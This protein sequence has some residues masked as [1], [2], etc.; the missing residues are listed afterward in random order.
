MAA[1]AFVRNSKTATVN[2]NPQTFE[3]FLNE[4]EKK[5]EKEIK[6][7][8]KPQKAT[9]AR[10]HV[11]EKLKKLPKGLLNA[12]LNDPTSPTKTM[13]A[14]FAAYGKWLVDEIL[15]RF[16]EFWQTT[17]EVG[18]ANIIM[19]DIENRPYLIN[20]QENFPT[21]EPESDEEIYANNTDKDAIKKIEMMLLEL[22][23]KLDQSTQ[24][25]LIATKE[26][27]NTRG[28]MDGELDTLRVKHNVEAMPA[29]SDKFYREL[30]QAKDVAQRN[31]IVEKHFENP[32]KDFIESVLTTACPTATLQIYMKKG[33]TKQIKKTQMERD[34][35]AVKE[36]FNTFD[37]LFKNKNYKLKALAKESLQQQKQQ[38]DLPAS[39]SHK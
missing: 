32:P 39:F 17:Q 35:Q 5:I 24:E 7:K 14:N 4:G 13:L 20:W 3:N 2:K 8:K 38:M 6:T 21:P 28:K 36:V 11:I 19:A 16:E 37:R 15:K 18:M 1:P 27:N 34:M 26:L 30:A 23:K 33:E 22:T 9:N 25:F 29:D 31:S 12:D 10:L